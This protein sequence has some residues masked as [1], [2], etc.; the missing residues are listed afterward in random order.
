MAGDWIKMRINL[1]DDP[2]VIAIADALD[3]DQDTVVGKLHRLWSWADQHTTHGEARGVATRWVDRFL[4]VDGFA[5]AMIDCGWLCF[6]G[7][8]LLFPGFAKHNGGSAKTRAENSLRARVSREQRDTCAT[9]ARP[10]KSERREE[11]REEPQRREE[12]SKKEFK[13]SARAGALAQAELSFDEAEKIRQT[14]REVNDTLQM[15][16]DDERNRIIQAVILARYWLNEAALRAAVD[17]VKQKLRAKTLAGDR[18]AYFVGCLRSAWLAEYPEHNRG[19]PGE[20][21]GR[22]QAFLNAI[23]IPEQLAAPPPRASPA[24]A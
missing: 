23:P 11:I 8:T 9:E 17:A 1:H 7:E 15:R 12:Q 22:F 16:S 13:T 14:C 5:Q 10:E 4:A 20:I 6:N 3:I 19:S 21:K 18:F 24:I 2:A